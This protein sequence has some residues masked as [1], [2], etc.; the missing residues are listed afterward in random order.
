MLSREG[1]NVWEADWCG[2]DVVAVASEDPGESAWYDSPL[3]LID[4]ATGADRVIATSD[5]Q[6]GLPVGSLDGTRAAV[7]EA[8]C[9]DRQLVS[10][11]AVVIDLATDARRGRDRGRRSHVAGMAHERRP[12]VH[13]APT[14]RHGVR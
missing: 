11:R 12:R 14:G 5:V 4:A 13:D 3:V 7:V 10:G 8:P 6:F 9:S 2:D 1:L